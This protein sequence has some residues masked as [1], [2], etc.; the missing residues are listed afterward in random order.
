MLSLATGASLEKTDWEA[1]PYIWERDDAYLTITGHLQE[2]MPTDTDE[3]FFHQIPTK[4]QRASCQT[5]NHSEGVLL[6]IGLKAS[7]LNHSNTDH[8]KNQLLYLQKKAIAGLSNLEK[9]PKLADFLDHSESL[10][11]R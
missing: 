2:L 3:K 9:A 10:E 8:G 7:H 4:N 5:T 1:L 6:P 11:A